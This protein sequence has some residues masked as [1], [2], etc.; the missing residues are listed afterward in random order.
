MTLL[1]SL[2]AGSVFLCSVMDV[3]GC[4]GGGGPFEGCD[5]Q[6]G[7]LRRMRRGGRGR[8]RAPPPVERRRPM[9]FSR[10]FLA[11]STKSNNMGSPTEEKA[12][13][14]HAAC[15]FCDAPF[16]RTMAGI[17]GYVDGTS[18]DTSPMVITEP[19]SSFTAVTSSVASRASISSVSPPAPASNDASGL[20]RRAHCVHLVA[21]SALD[22][23]CSYFEKQQRPDSR[24][25]WV[26]R[27]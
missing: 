5:H 23:K 15:A 24:R 25:S 12:S 18:T 7:P 20:A 11:A 16:L 26:E 27:L 17:D 2:C 9:A 4:D 10:W 3:L 8:R 6:S 13:V 1:A 19:W 14:A 21:K 22:N